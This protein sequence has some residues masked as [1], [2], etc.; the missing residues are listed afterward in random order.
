ME[1]LAIPGVGAIIT[2]VRDGK[3]CILLQERFKK[4]GLEK[5]GLLEIPAGKIRAFENIFDALR[6]EVREET[7]LEVTN[8]EGAEAASIFSGNGYRVINFTPFSCSQN[9]KGNYPVM[10][11]TFVCTAQGEL[12]SAS[13]E[14]NNYVWMDEAT[15]YQRLHENPDDFFPMHIDTLLKYLRIEKERRDGENP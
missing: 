10:V 13:D 15:L 11:F 2:G 3:R 7:G 14:S 4:D 5:S 8:I 6:R 9:T 12:L 1:A